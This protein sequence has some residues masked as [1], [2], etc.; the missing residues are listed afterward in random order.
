MAPQLQ[1]LLAG[2]P[3][4]GVDNG[5]IKELAVG[6]AALRGAAVGDFGSLQGTGSTFGSSP[7]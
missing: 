4:I 3:L 2:A 1:T 7:L 6:R 5:P